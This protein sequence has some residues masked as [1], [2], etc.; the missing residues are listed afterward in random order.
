MGSAD[1]K[2]MGLQSG[3]DRLKGDPRTYTILDVDISRAD[4][5]ARYEGQPTEQALINAVEQD[6][7]TREI[8]SRS[9][10]FLAFVESCRGGIGDDVHFYRLKPDNEGQEHKLIT[11]GANRTA[12]LRIVNDD[13]IKAGQEPWILRSVQAARPGS[14]DEAGAFAEEQHARSNVRMRMKPSHSARTAAKF[15]ARGMEAESIRTYLDGNPPVEDVDALVILDGLTDAIKD[16]VDAGTVKLCAIVR[17]ESASEAK[18]AKWLASRTAPKKPREPKVAKPM[19]R[20]ILA[21]LRNEIL[22]PKP[23]P[24]EIALFEF[25]CVVTGELAPEKIT[26][27]VLRAAYLRATERGK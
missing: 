13:R 11:K 10:E 6:R 15:A 3:G 4:L 22:S 26:G 7:R 17:L 5:L 14:G 27:P 24:E 16:A 20:K 18:Q 23:T 8:V 1:I 12:A 21:S 9:P 19:P 2:A 25:L